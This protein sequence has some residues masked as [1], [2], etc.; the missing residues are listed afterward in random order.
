MFGCSVPQHL[1]PSWRPFTPILTR[2]AHY[3]YPS[4]SCFSTCSRPTRQRTSAADGKKTSTMYIMN[5]VPFPRL[6]HIV[7]ASHFDFSLFVCVLSTLCVLLWLGYS[8][9]QADCAFTKCRE[10]RWNVSSCWGFCFFII[11]ISCPVV[12]SK[13]KKSGNSPVSLVL[14]FLSLS[15]AVSL[16]SKPINHI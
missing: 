9:K 8:R 13:V 10:K 1:P 3:I 16:I 11:S 12:G 2:F 7:R 6:F 4:W 15:E 5:L 14:S